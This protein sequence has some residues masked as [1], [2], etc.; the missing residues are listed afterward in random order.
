VGLDLDERNFL[1]LELATHGVCDGFLARPYP[2]RPNECY[3]DS[4]LGTSTVRFDAAQA[5]LESGYEHWAIVAGMPDVLPRLLLYQPCSGLQC[6]ANATCDQ[7]EDAYIWL[8]NPNLTTPT[9]CKPYGLFGR[10]ITIEPLGG[11]GNPEDRVQILYHG[12]GGIGAAVTWRCNR[13]VPAGR[14]APVLSPDDLARA[15]IGPDGW[16]SYTVASSDVC[17]AADPTPFPAPYYPQFPHPRSTPTPVPHPDPVHWIDL[18]DQYILVNLTSIDA[19]LSHSKHLLRASAKCDFEVFQRAWS[20]SPCPAGYVCD[21]YTR[22]SWWG[23][24]RNASGVS[25]C[26]PIGES[27]YGT[28]MALTEPRYPAYGVTLFYEGYGSFGTEVQIGCDPRAEEVAFFELQT[29]VDYASGIT[30][31]NY[32]FV[33]NS[34]LVCPISYAASEVPAP[35]PSPHAPE[36][37]NRTAFRTAFEN[38]FSLDLERFGPA[39]ATVL[40]GS[41]SLFEKVTIHL[42]MA[43]RIACPAGHAC[44]Y[45]DANVWKCWDA[46]GQH[47][48]VPI[49]DFRYGLTV[50]ALDPANASD[51]VYVRYAGGFGGWDTEIIITCDSSLPEAAIALAAF[52]RR[53]H[54]HRVVTLTARSSQ[55][56]DGHILLWRSDTTFGALFLTAVHIVVALYLVIGIIVAVCQEGKVKAPNRQFWRQVRTNVIVV[57]FGCACR[58]PAYVPDPSDSCDGLTAT[59]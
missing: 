30:G 38:K 13:S 23:C 7:S 47:T 31:A 26:C 52:A 21:E 22:G 53:V 49:G 44:P 3:F 36:P 24:W 41:D 11:Q 45:E 9:A 43:D 40:V 34:S 25:V 56:C 15:R 37:P 57:F 54:P 46:H 33:A 16:L 35:S 39:V 8:C 12:D 20:G 55:V 29:Y 48:C 14:I 19:G 10:G 28:R 2:D 17:P 18:G 42:S 1:K 5:D 4:P 58:P 6:P 59:G 32:S 27:A 51:G 50:D